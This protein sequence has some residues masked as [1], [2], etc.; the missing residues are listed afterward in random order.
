MTTDDLGRAMSTIDVAASRAASGRRHALVLSARAIVLAYVAVAVLWI[1]VSDQVAGLLFP[2]PDAR[3]LVGTLKGLGFVAV[4]SGLLA[5]L[6]RRHDALRAQQSAELERRERRYRLLAEHAQDIIFRVALGPTPATVYL[7][8]AVERLLGHPASAFEAAP[9]LLRRLVHPE[10]RALFDP[11]SGA[12]HDGRP[13]VVRMQHADGRWI[14]LE[15]RATPVLDAVGEA[16]AVDGVARDVTEHRL[17]EAALARVSRVERTLSAVN[18][19]LVRAAD[20]LPLLE[21]I[22]RAVI[23]EGGFRFVWVGYCEDDDAGT[24]RPVAH[25]GHEDGYLDEI[26][27]SWHDD[28]RGRGP[29]GVAVRERR[30]AIIR[31]IAVDPAMAPDVEAALARGYASSATLPLVR[32]D[33]V[34]GVLSIYSAERDAFGPGEVALLEQLAADLCYGVDAL[35]T[36][37]GGAAAEAERRRLAMA[38]EQSAESVV[39]TD[40]GGAIEYVNPTFERVTG[41]VAAEV[42]GQNPRLFRSGRQTRAFYEAMWKTL[43]EGRPWVGDMVNRRKDGS[44]FTQEAVI[45]PVHDEA[46]AIT[47]YVAVQREVTR[48]RETEARE[49]VHARERAQIAEA[50]AMLPPQ[51]TPEETADAVCH[52][53]VQLPEARA[54]VLLAFDS[55]G[56]ATPLGA[57]ATDGRVLERQRLSK[58]RTSH[59]QS[60]A[61][62]G[63]WVEGWEAS[64][65]Q[66]FSRAFQA[67]GLRAL[68]YAPIRIEQ[69]MVGL[70]EVGSAGEDASARMTERLPALVEF[71]SI[72]SAVLG[73]SMSS[74]AQLS[75]S[76]ERILAIMEQAAFHPVFQPIVDL[77]TLAVIGYEALTRFDDGTSPDGQFRAAA[78]MGLGVE[79]EVATLRAVLAAA[80]SPPAMP[81]L[82]VNVSPAV[83]LAGEPLRSLAAAYP[84]H[85]VLEVTEHAVISDYAA[86]REAVA[87]LGSDVQIAV[88]DAGAGFASLR[89]IVE[90]RPHIVKIDRSLVAGIDADPARQALLAGLRHFADSLG[91]SLIA[92]GIETEAELATLITLDV[93]SG[94]GYLLGRPGPFP[95]SPRRVRRPRSS[96]SDRRIATAAQGRPAGPTHP[97]VRGARRAAR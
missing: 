43:T 7:S 48:E 44:L 47:G 92:E 87:S 82:N 56:R 25:A 54:A 36:R 5:A 59:L 72:A 18:Q 95:A 85:L 60:R 17:V 39:I 73:P 75:R 90:L 96:T 61:L 93:R 21:A 24:I 35:R 81:W 52:Q 14:W 32:G 42:R 78:A 67:I 80:A 83:V 12:W 74:R 1:A 70:L 88:D 2:D 65:G 11:R 50:L 26:A 4:T 64:R 49:Q 27:L 13:F 84:G 30:P 76:R 23:D 97:A 22:C 10:D 68:A 37:A 55:D 69:A 29:A 89:H 58:A 16:V 91:C 51:A 63:P 34:A 41:Y 71:A 15:V 28:D 86:F 66:P 38:I 79:L 77:A 31:E 6:L 53:I 45:S 9:D 33:K 19:A 40:A 46:G 94:Q 8:P 3:A 57:A 20:E 62:E